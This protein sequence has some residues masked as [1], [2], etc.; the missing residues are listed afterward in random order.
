[1]YNTRLDTLLDYP[2]SRLRTLLDGSAAPAGM[3]PLSLSVGEPQ[4]QPPVELINAALLAGAETWN[5]YPPVPGT[6]DFRLACT[7]WLNRRYQLA[8]GYID[9]ASM[10]LPLAGSREGLFMAA[11]LAVPEDKG[12]Y[13]PAVLMPDPFY[14][15]Y[16]GAARFAGAEPVFLPATEETG[17]LPDLDAI[18]APLLDRT[19]LFYLCTPSNPQGAVASP[20]YLRKA[21]ALARKHDFVLAVDECYAEIYSHTPPTGA[22][23][24]CREMDGGSL[25]NVLVFHSLSKRSNAAGLRSGFMAGD[26]ALMARFSRMRSYAA[27]STPLP[28]LAASAALWRDEAHVVANRAAYS[29]KFDLADSIL[30]NRLGYRRP[31]GGFFLWLKVG[32]GEAATSRL[33]REAGIR[34]LPGAYLSRGDGGRGPGDPYIRV[35]M[36]HEPEILAPALERIVKVLDI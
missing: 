15:V 9:P 11:L 24:I 26:K 10:V 27:A 32:D 21:I 33:W 19:A 13:V 35:A 34:V 30:G 6:D 28:L 18:P 1:M 12:G 29:A 5:R 4:H 3:T 20:D 23:E 25:H 2:F 31:A 36:V 22:L 14:A 8:E 17:H 16:E 7:E